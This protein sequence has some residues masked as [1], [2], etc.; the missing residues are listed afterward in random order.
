MSRLVIISNRLPVNILTK[1]DELEIQPSVG[2][3]ATGL[4]SFYKSYDSIWL[5]WPGISDNKIKGKK[6]IIYEKLIKERCYPVFLSNKDITDYYYGFSNKTIWPLF[7]YFTQFTTYSEA[8]WEAYKR[9]NQKFLKTLSGIIKPNDIIWVHDYHLLLLSRLIK[10]KFPESR[11][12]FFLHIPFPS[13]EVFRLIPWRKEII[14]GMLGADL[15]GMHTFDYVRHFLSCV[16]RLLGH[17]HVFNLVSTDK[18]IVKAD[19]F[20]MGIDYDRF[21]KAQIEDKNFSIKKSRK[22]KSKIISDKLKDYKVII[23]V[24]RLDYTKGIPE[25]LRAFDRFLEKYP[26][27]CGKVVLVMVAVPSRTNVKEYIDLK[28]EVDELTGKINGKYGT[29]NWMPILYLYRSLPFQQL[30]TLYKVSDIALVTPLRDG[31]NLVAKEYLATKTDKKAVLIL[32]DMAGAAIELGEAIIVNP[33]NK[34]EIADAIK[35]AIEM[36]DDIKSESCTLMQNRLKRYNVEKW[37]KDFV[38]TTIGTKKIQNEHTAKKLPVAIKNEIIKKFGAA[39]KRVIF[40]DY[41]GTLVSFK[42]N[43]KSAKPD[44]QVMDLLQEL[45]SHPDNQVV[46]ISGREKESL[47]RWFGEFNL[48]IIAEHGTW[49]KDPGRAWEMCDALKNDW[50]REIRPI[51]EMYVDRTPGSFI[52]E[53]SFS[54]AWHYRESHP[55]LKSVRSWELKDA[56]INFTTNLNLEILEGSNV[57]EIKNVGSNKGKAALRTLE[58][59]EYDFILAIGDDW[60]DEYLFSALP[61]DAYTLKVGYH[62]SHARY[63]LESVDDV[64]ILLKKLL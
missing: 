1:N 26:E 54:L 21:S 57:I 48:I 51:M 3:L 17:E 19:S 15:I 22:S 7:H 60:T 46:I 13:Y 39:S 40:L 10:K 62:P 53:K 33:N 50:K 6:E 56:L 36:P 12:G 35:E 41:D 24:D 2:G 64:R 28:R 49:K 30:L 23:S 29:I 8:Q 47:F 63:S 45:S 32:S 4:N 44:K 11:I 27:Y 5:G 34:E 43:P 55:D 38:E 9:V 16:R 25:R 52:E 58:N 20:P 61:K 59:I 18:R 14:D 37:A 42:K 31:M